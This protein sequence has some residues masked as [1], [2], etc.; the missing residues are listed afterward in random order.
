MQLFKN[1]LIIFL[2]IITRVYAFKLQA[3]NPTV[4]VFDDDNDLLTNTASSFLPRINNITFP[5]TVW[6]G[7]GAT[8]RKFDDLGRHKDTDECCRNHD[9]C[10][11]ISA[12]ETKY[13][14]TND[15]K[16]SIMNCECEREFKKCLR[17]SDDK[18][19]SRKI[20]FLYFTLRNRCFKKEYPI[21]KCTSYEKGL[22]EKRCVR[23]D[24]NVTQP[25]LYQWFDIPFFGSAAY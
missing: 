9:N 2:T 24:V 11:Y 7:P 1:C 3:D 8:A 5:G 17:N 15:G 20:G 6:C 10:R 19:V 14:L 23:Y 13:D 12:G 21:I 25:K 18:I 4:Q 16:F 22:F